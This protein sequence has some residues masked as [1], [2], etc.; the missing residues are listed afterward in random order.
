MQRQGI[1]QQQNKSQSNIH[2]SSGWLQRAAVR[3][4]NELQSPVEGNSGLN[5]SFV[6]VPVRGDRLPV[7][8]PK[9]TIGKVGDRYEQ[10]ADRVASE[11]VQQINAPQGHSVQLQEAR[12]D[13][14]IQTKPEI[15]SLQRQEGIAG[16]EA[17]A[18]LT[19]A[20]NSARGSGQ[21]LDSGL[22]ARMGQ[23]MGAD[24]SS[25]RVHTDARSD[26][27]NQSLQAKA[28]T[29]GQDVF[30]RQGEYQ[31]G[32]RGGQELIAHELT[33]VVQQGGVSA[34]REGLVGVEG[35][36]YKSVSHER[37]ENLV[38]LFPKPHGNTRKAQC[39]IYGIFNQINGKPHTLQYVGQASQDYGV[40]FQQHTRNDSGY[41][42]YI[43]SPY[44]CD[45]SGAENTWPYTERNIV[46]FKN[47]LTW[48]ELT[49]A[50]QII[51]D[52]NGGKSKLLNQINPI[53]PNT[54]NKYRTLQNYNYKNL[55]KGNN[56]NVSV[57]SKWR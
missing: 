28:F 12:E 30:F 8:Q 36:L 10:E 27:L 38:Q 13:K 26:Q 53:L 44:N 17:S 49:V 37:A 48:M 4:E 43:G 34:Q 21:A 19:S 40:R 5:R 55:S 16:G 15:T 50:E 56:P 29:T 3:A 14:E 9:L 33:H 35:T 42:W 51:L 47:N 25:V 2:S 22:Q 20:I 23:A 54:F 57:P 32:S 6:N 52:A 46:T 31:P 7:V 18:D 39:H 41:P 11:V 1:N 24:F 45:Y